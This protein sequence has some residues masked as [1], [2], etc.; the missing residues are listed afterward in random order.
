MKTAF[1][2]LLDNLYAKT[3]FIFTALMLLGVAYLIEVITT[4]IDSSLAE[5]AVRIRYSLSTY[6]LRNSLISL[7]QL[8][9]TVGVAFMIAWI[10]ATVKDDKKWLLGQVHVAVILIVMALAHRCYVGIEAI[11]FDFLHG[12]NNGAFN[13]Y[14]LMPYDRFDVIG[15]V[16]Y[17]LLIF[18]LAR[19]LSRR[20]FGSGQ[21]SAASVEMSAVMAAD[22][23]T[24]PGSVDA[25]LATAA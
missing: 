14:W 17:A 2:Q 22:V 8:G 13:G 15:D 12:V 20:Y 3:K 6:G 18:Y 9:Y 25:K 16:V 23:T 24:T 7:T 4:S 19:K 1:R 5:D 11:G 10:M 21:I